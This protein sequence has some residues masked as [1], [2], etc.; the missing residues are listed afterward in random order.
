[1]ASFFA[2]VPDFIAAIVEVKTG[3]GREF[4]FN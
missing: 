1:M 4:F 3:T 2:A